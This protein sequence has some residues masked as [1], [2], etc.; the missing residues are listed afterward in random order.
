[1]ITGLGEWGRRVGG[2]RMGIAIAASVG[3]RLFSRA[4]FTLVSSEVL[5]GASFISV[6]LLSAL[7]LAICYTNLTAGTVLGQE[8]T[9]LG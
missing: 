9:V 6:L 7:P 4:N 8:W 2:R 5:F 1:M 3:H